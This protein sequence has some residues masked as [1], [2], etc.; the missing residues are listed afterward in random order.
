MND[1]KQF[2]SEEEQKEKNRLICQR[3]RDCIPI[4]DYAASRGFQL[5]RKGKYYQIVGKKNQA[6]F[7]SVMINAE[8]NRYKHYSESRQ[9]HSI[10][11]F[12]MEL[13]NCSEA[14]AI[15]KLKPLIDTYDLEKAAPVKPITKKKDTSGGEI[16][17][18]VPANTTKH[19]YAYLLKTRKINKDVIDYFIYNDILYQDEK[20]NAVFVKYN[21]QWKPTFC[22]KRGTNTNYP[23]MWADSNN[24]YDHC[25][26]INNES[27]VLIVNESIIDS[28]SLMSLFQDDGRDWWIYSYLALAGAANWE[29]VIN[30]LKENPIIKKV[31]VAFD[32]DEG[33]FKNMALLRQRLKEE[34]EEIECVDFLP[35]TVNDWNEQLQWNKEHNITAVQYFRSSPEALLSM[36]AESPKRHHIKFERTEDISL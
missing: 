22:I 9:S 2:L 1:A 28:M 35:K 5:T 4:Q 36:I 7:S 31:V 11:D 15:E 27:D 33:G 8:T 32:N 6:D 24:D 16:I 17:L 10:I 29:A 25:H 12:V 26:L 3:I 13:D 19:V 23:F 14:E 20:K 34:F 18:P 21:K 30:T